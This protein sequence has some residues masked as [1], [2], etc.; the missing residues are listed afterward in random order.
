MIASIDGASSAGGLSGALGGP[1]G[2]AVFAAL[3]CLADVVVVGA[4]TMR[5]ES[6][7]PVRLDNAARARRRAWG[8]PEVSPVAVVTRSCRLD[9]ESTF[10]TDAEQ[11]PFVLTVHAAAE[12]D[13]RRA[14]Q[15]AEVVVAGGR[16]V[17]PARA[18]GALAHRGAGNVLEEGGPSLNGQ[19][20]AA[21]VLDALCL[22]LSPTLLVGAAR[23]IATGA[24]LAPPA[25]LELARVL[26]GGGSLFL[27]YRR[28]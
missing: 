1:S 15:A 7:G 2:K 23:R 12:A 28:P 5:A 26:E 11:T 4:A 19:L 27:R 21:G 6:Y 14:G 8:V 20:A 22:T 16:D 3:R 9:C 25:A 10:F 13:R 17:E 18:L 24:A